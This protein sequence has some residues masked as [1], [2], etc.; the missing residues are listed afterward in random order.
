MKTVF[1]AFLL[2]L[3]MVSCTKQETQVKNVNA[4]LNGSWVKPQYVDTLVTYTRAEQLIAN[5]FGY[6]F[7]SDN[8]LISR[9]NSGWCGTPPIVTA[10]Y[11]GTWSRRDSV[12]N[13]TTGFWGGTVDYTWK[14]ISL[15]EQK[16]VIWVTKSDFHTK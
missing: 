9:Q 11:T 6:T 4:E 14:I 10:D 3:V 15:D 2:L 16:L 5:E 7:K 12:V 1:N 13:I 8:S